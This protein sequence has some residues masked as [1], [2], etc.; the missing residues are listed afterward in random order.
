MPN[1]IEFNRNNEFVTV[2][3]G[4]RV[5]L[6][7]EDEVTTGLAVTYQWYYGRVGNNPFVR[8]DVR[9][10]DQLPVMALI[11]ADR[12]V[13]IRPDIDGFRGHLIGPV[14]DDPAISGEEGMRTGASLTVASRITPNP[15]QPNDMGTVYRWRK[16][17]Y[18]NGMAIAAHDFVVLYAV[19]TVSVPP[20]RVRGAGRD[21]TFSLGTSAIAPIPNF[22]DPGVNFALRDFTTDVTRGRAAIT[23]SEY[24]WDAYLREDLGVRV[25]IPEDV[26]VV[27]LTLSWTAFYRYP[28]RDIEVTQ[29]LLISIDLRDIRIPAWRNNVIVGAGE[30]FIDIRRGRNLAEQ[31]KPEA[32]DGERYVGATTSVILATSTDRVQVLSGGGG[33][34]SRL[35]ASAVVRITQVLQIEMQDI[36]MQNLAL[37]ALTEGTIERTTEAGEI[38]ETVIANPGRWH[39]LVAPLGPGPVTALAARKGALV[40]LRQIDY[41]ADMRRGRIYFI[42][43][44]AVAAGDTVDVT[45]TA[46]GRTTKCVEARIEETPLAALRYIEEP[47][48]GVHG[49]DWY[50]PLCALLSADMAAMLSRDREQRILTQWAVLQPITG[51]YASTYI[52]G[53]PTPQPIDQL[54]DNA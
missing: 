20:G 28:N 47:A 40:L 24:S 6:S 38:A 52:D 30:L 15:E 51:G 18:A 44:G 21:Q 25:V 26:D 2:P 3:W 7:G 33:N 1:G 45:A 43:G 9:E 39:Q 36:S 32:L 4:E 22:M 11:P 37:A 42:P 41:Q 5:T 27:T 29:Q 16:I 54:V 17:A 48:H 49:R 35:L 8:W 34:L 31:I 10:D 53:E 50:W 46:R 12:G 14:T 19:A 13:S 23:V